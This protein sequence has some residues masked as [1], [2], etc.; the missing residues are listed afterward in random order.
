MG[1]ESPKLG[2]GLPLMGLGGK[3]EGGR[4]EALDLGGERNFARTGRP[5]DGQRA[6]DLAGLDGLYVAAGVEGDGHG[7]SLSVVVMLVAVQ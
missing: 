4:S 2:S 5:Q 1:S 7:L 3:F 6:G